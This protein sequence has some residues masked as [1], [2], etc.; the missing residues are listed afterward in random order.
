MATPASSR[1]TVRFGEFEADLRSGE[2]WRRGLKIKLAD[3]SFQILALLLERPGEVVTREELRQKLWT[4]DT[5]VDFEAG[6]NSAVKRLRDA[7]GDSADEPRFIETLPRRGYRFLMAVQVNGRA[8]PAEP[9]AAPPPLPQT[10]TAWKRSAVAVAAL[11]LLAVAVALG[12]NLGGF[13]DRLFGGSPKI[14]SLAVLPLENLT[15]DP[16][17]EYLVDGITDALITDLAQISSLRVISRTSVMTYKGKPKPLPQIARELKVDAVVEGT[18]SRSGN[19]VRVNA[20]LIDAATDRHLWA[21]EYERDLDDIL[22]LQSELARTIAGEVQ[23]ALTPQEQARLA[24][25]RTVDPDIYRLYLL[26]RFHWNKRTE[27]GMLKAIEYFDQAIAQ[28]PSYAPAYAGLADSNNLLGSFGWLPPKKAYPTAKEAALKALSLDEGLVAAH[29]SLADITASYE[30]NFSESERL[31]RRAIALNPGDPTAH[32][33]YAR[34]LGCRGQFDQALAE[35]R[36]AQELDPLSPIVAENVGII[37]YW[38]RRYDEAI[39]QFHTAEGLDPNYWRVH[40]SLGRAYEMAG[41]TDEAF[42]AYQRERALVG[43]GPEK[44]AALTEAYQRSGMR[45]YWRKRL[46]LAERDWAQREYVSPISKAY[47]YMA[48]GEKEQALGWLRTGFEER[49]DG[50][51]YLAVQPVWDPLRDDPRFQDLVRRVGVQSQEARAGK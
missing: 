34:L 6:L 40:H 33:W 37:L 32:Y 42:A 15:G 9:V 48:A 35:I 5:F 14:R 25:A 43:V 3:Q 21:Q 26:G 12:F 46:E 19:R 51:V 31:F 47:A 11:V 1:Q 44:I 23:V 28:D 38:A 36:R 7:L 17:Q 13:R 30:W 20:Q 49:S 8:T 22:V 41:K 50:V 4:E 2:L 39:E 24:R 16:A 45:G 29:T 18:V 27:G 10:G